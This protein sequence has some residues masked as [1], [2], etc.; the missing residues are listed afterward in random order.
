MLKIS[1]LP[2]ENVFNVHVASVTPGVL[3]SSPCQHNNGNCSHLCLP[4][5]KTATCACPARM[6]LDSDM[7]RCSIR[8]FPVEIIR[9]N[10]FVRSINAFNVNRL[11]RKLCKLDNLLYYLT[12][13]LVQLFFG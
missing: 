5:H 3:P 12:R 11:I 6:V 7:K 1:D 9:S 4:T 8:Y 13:Y 2:A 10:A